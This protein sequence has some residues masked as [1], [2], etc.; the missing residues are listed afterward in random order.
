MSDGMFQKEFNDEIYVKDMMI[1][2]PCP[3]RLE[4][5]PADSGQVFAAR[6][7][8][9]LRCVYSD[10]DSLAAFA[11][12][13]TTSYYACYSRESRGKDRIFILHEE[14]RNSERV[15]I[16]TFTQLKDDAR[17]LVPADLRH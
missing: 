2:N 5:R 11:N 14:S 10:L 13:D 17:S 1:K 12:D 16:V 3:E 7:G 9:V 8:W 15:E 4:M 6:T